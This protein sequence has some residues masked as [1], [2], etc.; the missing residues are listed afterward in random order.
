MP[1]EKSPQQ[2]LL[3]DV[4]NRFTFHP[5]TEVTGTQFDAVRIYLGRVAEKFAKNLPDSREK[6]LALT[7]LEEAMFWANASIARHPQDVG[8][9]DAPAEPAKK[10]AAKKTARRV[11]RTKRS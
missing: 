11:T 7:H 6:S 5:A 2:K 4:R 10:T 1:R 3:E 8:S 9:S